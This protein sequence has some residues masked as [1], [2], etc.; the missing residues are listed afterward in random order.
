M[1]N[2]TSNRKEKG[3]R[4]II[5]LAL[6][7]A[8]ASLSIT[9]AALSQN[10]Y[11]NGVTTLKGSTWD[12]HFE[13]LSNP[14]VNGKTTI[15]AP[16]TLTTTTMTFNVQLAEPGDSVMYI[17]D[18]KNSGTIDAKL[19]S[20][21]VLDGLTEAQAKKANYTFTYSDGT[22][23][24]ADDTLNSGETKTVKLVID[25]A[26]DA[27]VSATSVNLNLSTTLTYIQK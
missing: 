10:L 19:A 21:P 20:D 14:S 16:A 24:K 17:W 2:N 18:I 23:I 6:I 15:I 8:V 13:N 7:I 3:Y 26:S 11:I 1:D 9:Y 22:A 25:L 12:V 5:V 4:I 27:T